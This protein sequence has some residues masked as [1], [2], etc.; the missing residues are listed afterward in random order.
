MASGSVFLDALRL[1]F[2]KVFIR[3]AIAKGVAGYTAQTGHAPSAA[4]QEAPDLENDALWR[5]RRDLLGCKPNK[6]ARQAQPYDE[7]AVGLT[8][9]QIREAGG[10][11]E[12]PYWNV[13]GQI[14]RVIRASGSF[15]HTLEGE[16]RW[17][18]PPLT[19]PDVVVAVG[20]D[21]V[22]LPPYLA[23]QPDGS[24]TRGSGPKWMTR[25]AF[26]ATL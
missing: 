21:D 14:V 22:H 5:I 17:D 20:A 16:Y 4:S 8:L 1:K 2:S 19:A 23:R 6:P 7:P 11:A 15:L 10:T 3:R 24:I 18:M 26:E 25:A 13:N 9:L 12:G